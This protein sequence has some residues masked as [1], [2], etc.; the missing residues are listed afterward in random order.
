MLKR[1]SKCAFL[2]PLTVCCLCAAETNS[3]AV[4]EAFFA[5]GGIHDKSDMYTGEMLGFTT[6]RTMGQY[7]GPSATKDYRLLSL[8]DTNAVY[9]VTVK[10]NGKTQDWY[11]FV[12]KS[13]GAWRL[14][15]VRTLAQTGLINTVAT[16]LRQKRDRSP[17]EEWKLKNAD[18]TLQ[19]DAELRAYLEGNLSKFEALAR[20]IQSRTGNSAAAAKQ[21]YLT[22][23]RARESGIVEF[24]I[25]GIL[26]DTVGYLYVPDGVSPPRLQP[27]DVI[28][29]E[30]IA[31]HW[32][33]FKTT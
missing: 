24:I 21:L 31:D 32:Y 23:A 29:I 16:A 27:D 25:G 22:S 26:D 9:A 17:D 12:R 5:P 7:L 10:A 30:R 11:A 3:K 2:F 8:Y 19:S 18:L 13:N 28:Y 33:I 15:A 6:E 1:Y 20:L 14:E 4:V